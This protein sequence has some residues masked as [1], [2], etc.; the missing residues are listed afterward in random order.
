MSRHV[1][2]NLRPKQSDWNKASQNRMD[3]VIS[4]LT[5]IKTIKMLGLVQ[6]V[7]SHLQNLRTV[8][9]EAAKKLSWIMVMANAS[10]KLHDFTSELD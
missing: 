6:T 9:V 2:R 5:S 7:R 3:M 10:G 8:E 1:A 4:S